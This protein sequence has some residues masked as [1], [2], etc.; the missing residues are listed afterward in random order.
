MPSS[1]ATKETRQVI[2]AALGVT[3]FAC[4]LELGITIRF[5][6]HDQDRAPL[7]LQRA[8]T[9]KEFMGIDRHARFDHVSELQD[10]VRMDMREVP[11]HAG[12]A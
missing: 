12:I 2:S 9:P 1:F 7:I 8:E 5:G 3:E 11:W 6:Y 4:L 10:S